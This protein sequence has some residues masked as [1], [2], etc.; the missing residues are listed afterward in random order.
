MGN[1]LNHLMTFESYSSYNEDFNPFSKEDWKDAG[2]SIRRGVGFLTPEEIMEKGRKLVLNHPMRKKVYD[3]YLH[4]GTLNG[5]VY[6]SDPLKAREYL[7]FWA[8]AGEYANPVWSD[9]KK[10]FIDKAMRY[11]GSAPGASGN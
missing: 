7:K 4:G 5:K 6:A 11:S 10:K 2:S 1:R 3:T 9:E 8:T